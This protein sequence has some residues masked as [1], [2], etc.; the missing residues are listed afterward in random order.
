MLP[1]NEKNRLYINLM[2]LKGN[3]WC[4]VWDEFLASNHYQE[5]VK[6][7]NYCYNEFK[8]LNPNWRQ[9]AFKTIKI[10]I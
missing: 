10:N 5:A 4:P 9:S 8:K 3:C 2:R 6:L 1:L 7:R